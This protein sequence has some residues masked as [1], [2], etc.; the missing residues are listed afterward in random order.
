MQL[1]GQWL[2]NIH[3]LIMHTKL[4]FLSLTYTYESAHT[5]KHRRASIHLSSSNT[6]QLAEKLN[7]D[8]NVIL[9]ILWLSLS[10]GR[11]IQ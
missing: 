2:N 6:L 7:T 3:S 8:T 1:Y 11:D 4:N 10:S 5:L 9:R